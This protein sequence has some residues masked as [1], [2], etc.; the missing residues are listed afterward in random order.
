MCSRVLLLERVANVAI[1]ELGAIEETR[2][3]SK[4]ESIESLLNKVGLA[5]GLDDR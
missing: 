3:K 5:L 1:L 4:S 2:S